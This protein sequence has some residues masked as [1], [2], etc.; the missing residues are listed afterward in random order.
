MRQWIVGLC[1]S[2][3][4]LL[5]G[6]PAHSEPIVPDQKIVGAESP[7]SLGE[8]AY[9]SVS[10]ISNKPSELVSSAY[11]WRV[12]YFENSK[13]HEKRVIE[14]DNGIYFGAG[15]MSRRVMAFVSVTH[16]F[17][18]KDQTGNVIDVQTVTRFL[19]Q[20]VI[21]GDG[22]QPTPVPPPPMPV[23][24]PPVPVPP[25]PPPPPPPNVDPVFPNGKYNMSK[26]FYDIVKAKVP[27]SPNKQKAAFALAASYK[28]IASQIAAGVLK[29]PAD[30]LK[31]TTISN[32]NAI[33]SVGVDRSDWLPAFTDLQRLTF[34]LY[35]RHL[36]VAASD[37]AILMN[38]IA[39]ALD[40][41][42]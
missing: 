33:A 9:L 30:I 26:Q 8:L 21:L 31:K 42:R 6:S 15:I 18:K 38:E 10:P 41:V 34:D 14:S 2:A 7:I 39:L 25:P 32:Q 28:S 24:P 23:P 20:E 35:D 12:L 16:L 29:D 17:V 40:Q 27:A 37:Y 13:F 11:K 36:L 22:T 3:F 4:L 19:S 5:V 1:L